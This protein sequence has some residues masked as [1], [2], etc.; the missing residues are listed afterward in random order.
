M[1]STPQR[2]ERLLAVG[3]QCSEPHCHLVDFL[4]FK[5]QHCTQ[6]YCAEHFKVEAHKCSQYDE[7]KHDRV[8]PSCPMCNEP[9]AIPPGQDPNIRMERH[10]DT[11]CSVLTGKR[12]KKSAPV[13]ARGKCGKNCK[14]QFCPA[15]RFP[16]DHACAPAT[17]R[18]PA[19]KP[20]AQNVAEI[21][22][23]A[24]AAG[25][26]AAE[27]VKRKW[28]ALP[29]KTS[30]A[31][32]PARA[33]APAKLANAA[34]TTKTPATTNN[35]FSKTDSSSPSASPTITRNTIVIVNS[36]TSNMD[37]NSTP[38]PSPTIIKP[39]PVIDFMSR[40]KAERESRRR[41]MEERAKK[42]L[43]SEDEKA[44]LAAEAAQ[45]A[46]GSKKDG[47]VIM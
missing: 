36:S 47:C 45:E 44:I 3:Q 17:T 38:P 30:T 25:N 13:C 8:A 12:Q 20:T 1:A 37:A 35:P 27:A 24:S 32:R 14:Q 22:A 33:P 42:G 18:A 40:A 19:N 11:E 41:A 46:T 28:A 16:A 34:P 2:D 26:S 4:P 6:P 39:A 29:T 5:C 43:L 9:V 15:H 21:S 31:A 23:K 10:M 7:S